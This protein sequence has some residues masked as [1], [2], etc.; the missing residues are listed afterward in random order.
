MILSARQSLEPCHKVV[1]RAFVNAIA[2]LKDV[3]ISFSFNH[4][5]RHIDQKAR[6]RR[7]RR[8]RYELVPKV[9]LLLGYA[10]LVDPK[11]SQSRSYFFPI[12]KVNGCAGIDPGSLPNIDAYWAPAHHSRWS[13]SARLCRGSTHKLKVKRTTGHHAKEAHAVGS[14]EG[15]RKNR[16]PNKD[17]ARAH[18]DFVG[19]VG[20]LDIVRHATAEDNDAANRGILD[21]ARGVRGHP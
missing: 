3:K 13:Q 18:N 2:A 14:I 9:L 4:V 12:H 8:G 17:F 6:R 16:V 19:R 5:R 10:I 7:S 11:V 1:R 15:R 20:L 21:H